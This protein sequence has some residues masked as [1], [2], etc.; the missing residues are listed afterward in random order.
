M[1]QLPM[2]AGKNL[3]RST[4]RRLKSGASDVHTTI[5]VLFLPRAITS[6]RTRARGTAALIRVI[7]IQRK[8]IGSRIQDKGTTSGLRATS[9]GLDKTLMRS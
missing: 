1:G 3:H 5:R 6:T 4:C 9:P 8:V 7:R 2:V